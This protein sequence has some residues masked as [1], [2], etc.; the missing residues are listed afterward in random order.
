MRAII[1][2]VTTVEIVCGRVF[3][4]PR[5]RLHSLGPELRRK[6]PLRVN[7]SKIHQMLI[8]EHLLNTADKMLNI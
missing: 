6:I 8:G 7:F 4:I 5:C 3:L 1:F 2:Q